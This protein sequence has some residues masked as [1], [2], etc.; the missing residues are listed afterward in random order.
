LRQRRSAARRV[1]WEDGD[2]LAGRRTRQGTLSETIEMRETRIASKKGESNL[3]STYLALSTTTGIEEPG[4]P[5][6]CGERDRGNL[7]T[8]VLRKNQEF[9]R[10]K[11]HKNYRADWS[12]RRAGLVAHNLSGERREA[13]FGKSW[14]RKV[15]LLFG[16]R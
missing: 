10:G 6:S 8:L 5:K 3:G 15:F 4:E 12:G 13:E 2:T 1:L 11:S 7:T 16:S 14:S 9:K